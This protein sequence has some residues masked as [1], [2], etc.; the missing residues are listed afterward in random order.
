[1][2]SRQLIESSLLYTV[3][4]AFSRSPSAYRRVISHILRVLVVKHMD[5]LYFTSKI[6]V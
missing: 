2:V 5:L 4:N 3:E 1:M 6:L